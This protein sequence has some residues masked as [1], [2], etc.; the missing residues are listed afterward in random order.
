[1]REKKFC[2]D[3]I[4]YLKVKKFRLTKIYQNQRKKRMTPSL[5]KILSE[6]EVLREFGPAKNQSLDYSDCKDLIE[7]INES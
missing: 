2:N 5:L 7:Q 4:F 3:S 6:T 1:M